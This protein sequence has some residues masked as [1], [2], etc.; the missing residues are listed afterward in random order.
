M[1]PLSRSLV[2]LLTL[3]A[4]SL[5]I[6]ITGK[7]T[8]VS[9][10]TV[11]IAA[12]VA[13]G[14]ARAGDSVVIYFQ[15]PGLDN[16]AKVGSGQVVSVQDG[17]IVARIDQRTG[18]L[19]VGQIAKVQ[20]TGRPVPSERAAPV[21]KTETGTQFLHFDNQ[22]VG[23]LAT[24]AFK[25]AGVRWVQ[26]EGDP[27]IHEPEPN[28]VLPSGRKRVLL[29]TG[30]PVTSLTF[31]F[32]PP[33]KGFSLTRIGTAGGASVP[34]WRLEAF[35]RR[36]RR[37]GSTGEEHGLPLQP[38]QFS[39]SGNGIVRVLLSTDNRS[40]EGT[41]ATWNSLPIVELKLDR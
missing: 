4:I 5:G 19:A 21:A 8:A 27:R 1:P 13:K 28:M 9:G 6:E 23:W 36:G 15:I 11:T 18:S 35:D 25:S 2:S 17:R 26:G 31:E 22:W 16:L 24:D 30:G 32:T 39:V 40:G 33:V 7:V 14:Q 3:P 37:I 12:E 20:A 41:W 10:D 34:T 29:L 38:Q